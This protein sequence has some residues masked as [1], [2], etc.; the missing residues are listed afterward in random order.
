[1]GLGIRGPVIPKTKKAATYVP[2]EAVRW[3]LDHY[4]VPMVDH[5][6]TTNEAHA[7]HYNVSLKSIKTWRAKG[8]HLGMWSAP[9]REQW[10]CA[11]QAALQLIHR[12]SR[13]LL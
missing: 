9:T 11:Q 8:M 10:V 13:H 2:P 12:H 5:M 7:L 3:V 6:S 1:V 4:Q